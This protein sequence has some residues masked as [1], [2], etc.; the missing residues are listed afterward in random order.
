MNDSNRLLIF[1]LAVGVFGIIN[2]EMGVIGILPELADRFQVSISK[3]GLLVSLF[4]LAIAIAGPTM[5][6]IFSGMNRKNVMIMVLV[7]FVIS[8]IVAVFTTSFTILLLTR[9]IPAFFHP[10]YVSLALTVAGNSVSE[11]ESPKAIAKVFIGVSAG[12]VLGVPVVSYIAQLTTVQV[13]MS[14][15]V[16]V[17][18]LTLIATVILVPSMPVKER[19]SYGSQL[20]ILTNGIIW[21]SVLAV[22]FINAAIF[23]IY[24]YLAEYLLKVT[25]MSGKL[26]SLMLLF[27]GVA[28]IFGNIIA[29]RFLSTNPIK[30]VT[31]FPATLITLYLVFYPL[32]SLSFPTAII[33]IIWGVLA[34]LGANINQ[35][36]VMSA[37]PTAPDFAN[38]LFLTSV[39]LGT[40]IGAAVAGIVIAKIGTQEILFVGIA[41]LIISAVFIHWRKI[42]Q[43]QY[44][45]K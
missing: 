3:A 16:I 6:L 28:N 4:A 10:V 26:I 17:N 22:L 41:G 31:V 18:I 14:F 40:T 34:G 37:A 9:V 21:L 19:Q 5:P 36:W 38:G 20:K 8:N 25:Q 35:Y 12:M 27:Y 24:S 30:T 44:A 2:T 7:I 45:T 11:S 43:R 1:I 33:I 29:G 42:K 32:A 39:N 23:G 15:F 13:A